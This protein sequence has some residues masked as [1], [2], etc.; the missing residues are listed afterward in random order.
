MGEDSG[1]EAAKERRDRELI[2]L[3]NELRVAL[4]GVQVLFAF[5]LTVPFSQRFANLT[6]F[7][8]R[9]YFAALMCASA[10]S[11]LLIAPSAYHRV[12]F[13][14]G[15]KETMLRISNVLAVTG[16]FALALAICTAVLLI[17][18]I[19]FAGS[20]VPVIVAINAAL[21]A[22]LWFVLPTYRKIKS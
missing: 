7:Q 20:V 3:L 8:T 13:R 15:D 16:L 1:D 18:D 4:P 19:L 21:F 14:E 11:A 10:A 17:T 12:M 2:E 6:E 5:L 22:I 9:V